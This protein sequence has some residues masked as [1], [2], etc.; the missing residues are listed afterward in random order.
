[1]KATLILED[2]YNMSK[3]IGIRLSDEQEQ[4]MLREMTK[5]NESNMSEHIRRVYFESLARESESPAY[6]RELLENINANV[7]KINQDKTS[8]MS[9]RIQN[10]FANTNLN[11]NNLYEM[12][13]NFLPNETPKNL[14]TNNLVN[15][16]VNNQANKGDKSNSPYAKGKDKDKI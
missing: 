11:I 10:E 5:N 3:F 6:E 13:L 12:M 16:N 14:K 9:T 2:V 7:I 8:E 4:E 15:K 1:M